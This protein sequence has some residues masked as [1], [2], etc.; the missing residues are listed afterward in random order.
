MNIPHCVLLLVLTVSLGVCQNKYK[1]SLEDNE[2]A[3]FEDFEEDDDDMNV[4]GVV[5]SPASESVHASKSKLV[6]DDSN[7]YA[8]AIVEV[9]K[10]NFE[11]YI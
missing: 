8:G 11:G 10:S 5:E 4:I 2:F 9:R 3:E 7:D 6:D 1:E